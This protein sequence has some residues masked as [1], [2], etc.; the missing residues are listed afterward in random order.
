ML[1]AYREVEGVSLLGG[2]GVEEKDLIAVLPIFS[3][4]MEK[5]PKA[6]ILDFFNAKRVNPKVTK[7]L[8]T[9]GLKVLV[10]ELN[11]IAA[12]EARLKEEEKK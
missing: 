10:T 8:A 5:H 3:C 12:L 4:W 7:A 1:A 11:Q 9:I 6:N 2:T